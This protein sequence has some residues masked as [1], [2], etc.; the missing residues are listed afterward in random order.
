[1]SEAATH[2][3]SNHRVI[4]KTD[5]AW[6]GDAAHVMSPFAGEGVNQG[7]PRASSKNSA[8]LYS[9]RP[10]ARSRSRP[11]LPHS[12]STTILIHP[13]IPMLLLHQ[14]PIPINPT[15]PPTTDPTALR[16]ALRTFE[17]RMMRRARIEMKSSKENL[18]ICFGP[19]PARRFR[20]QFY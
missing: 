5:E 18:E 4:E 13:H 9:P 16:K 2:R 15:K 19:E 20:N 6:I 14:V 7:T 17:A 11:P 1:M 10:R 8:D 3:A 12:G